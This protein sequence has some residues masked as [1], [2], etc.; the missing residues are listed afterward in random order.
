MEEQIQCCFTS[1][2]SECTDLSLVSQH[3]V[4]MMKYIPVCLKNNNN[5]PKVLSNIQVINSLQGIKYYFMFI[6]HK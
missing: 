2:N 5:N 3:H 6:H 4:I 1:S